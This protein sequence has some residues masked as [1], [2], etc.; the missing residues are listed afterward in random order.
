MCLASYRI[1]SIYV[2][3]LFND[4][5]ATLAAYASFYSLLQ[6]KYTISSIL[7]SLAISIKMNILLFAPAYA[8]IFYENLGLIR[9][10]KK[11]GVVFGVQVLLAG[12]FLYKDPLAYLKRSFNF[13][14]IFL[15][16]WTV[17]WRFLDER[18]F[19]SSQFF[20]ILICAQILL[21]FVMFYRRWINALTLN[22][23]NL[24]PRKDDPILTLFIANFIGVA[25]SRSLHYQFYIWYYHSLPMI[26][27]A[28]K[29]N[30]VTKLLILGCIEYSWNAYPSTTFSSIL[31][32]LS[33]LSIIIGLLT[34]H[35][36]KQ[37]TNNNEI[38]VSKSSFKS[39]N[40]QHSKR[41]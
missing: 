11:A 37:T 21:L 27:W 14:R 23:F 15:H 17:N 20:R 1:H 41:R 28:T 38:S 2:L 24:N 16:Q 30:V 12:P 32:H 4:P 6:K 34:R 13:G 26:L 9:S 18:V 29:Y 8:L 3:R 40:K 33:H 5:I 10:I 35:V 31:L 39:R 7:F 36:F 22:Q 25:F 19:T